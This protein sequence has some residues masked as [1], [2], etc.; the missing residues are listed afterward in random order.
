MIATFENDPMKVVKLGQ[1]IKLKINQS[2]QRQGR[3]QL[4]L[5]VDGIYSRMLLLQ[6]KKYAAKKLLFDEK[7]GRIRKEVTTIVLFLFHFQFH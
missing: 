7:N 6:K 2:F 1:S 3:Q 5:D 4:Q